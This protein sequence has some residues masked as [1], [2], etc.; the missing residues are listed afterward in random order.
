MHISQDDIKKIAHLA[1]LEINASEC[2]QYENE[3]SKI[4]DFV[5]EL[6]SA[7]IDNTISPMAYPIENAVQ[8]LRPDAVTETDRATEYQKN[9]PEVESGLYLVPKVLEGAE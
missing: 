6:Q 8:R 1:K 5:D 3:L 9:A 4:L 7:P 2:T